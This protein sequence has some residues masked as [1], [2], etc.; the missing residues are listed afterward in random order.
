MKP[1]KITA[2]NFDKI[3][4]ALKAVN[5]RATSHAITTAHLIDCISE[6]AEK[7]LEDAGVPKAARAGC[8]LTHVPEGPWAKAYKYAARTTRVVLERRATGWF[9]VHIE[10]DEVYP[11]EKQLFELC[12][13]DEQRRI[14]AK[15]ALNRFY[16]NG[17]AKQLASHGLSFARVATD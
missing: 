17:P 6:E 10:Q 5:G 15:A 16:L 9:L 8:R 1:I 7:R 11:R 3:E 2:K 13:T 12:V 14:I 4:E